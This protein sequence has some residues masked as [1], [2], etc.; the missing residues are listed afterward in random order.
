M[1]QRGIKKTDLLLII[2]DKM[3][4]ENITSIPV[5]NKVS[6][7]ILYLMALLRTITDIS[8]PYEDFAW[9]VIKQIST[10]YNQTDRAPNTY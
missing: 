2:N 9:R 1:D 10:G 6:S 4:N 3:I 8:S 5:T 7:Y